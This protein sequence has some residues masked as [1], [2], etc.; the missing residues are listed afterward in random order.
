MTLATTFMATT[1]LTTGAQFV[2]LVPCIIAGLVL[3]TKG[4]VL[5]E[6]GP[7][8]GRVLWG[9]LFAVAAVTIY[10]A[11][12]QA[13]IYVGCDHQITWLDWIFWVC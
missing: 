6:D 13:A 10:S 11:T 3:L 7:T 8:R 4:G 2:L 12:T 1:H 9:L 5:P